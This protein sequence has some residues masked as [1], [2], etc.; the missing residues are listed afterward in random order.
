MLVHRRVTPR[1]MFVSTYLYI[2]AERGTVREK[3]LEHDTMS[4]ARALNRTRQ[5]DDER[6]NREATVLP[7]F[8]WIQLQN[9]SF[10][11]QDLFS[12][13][14]STLFFVFLVEIVQL[15]GRCKLL[16][17][18]KNFLSCFPK[19]LS[20]NV[21]TLIILMYLLWCTSWLGILQN[22]SGIPGND[23]KFVRLDCFQSTKGV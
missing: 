16:H 7:T 23:R 3:C 20:N 4:I 17:M 14:K 9:H 11:R 18:I 5:S 1:I 8:R 6:T 10:K 13:F 19:H 2:W 21:Y 12:T 15:P 22:L